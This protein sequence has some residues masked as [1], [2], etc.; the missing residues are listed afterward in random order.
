VSPG[1]RNNREDH[2]TV[3]RL[4]AMECSAKRCWE[5]SGVG[6]AL[7]HGGGQMPPGGLGLFRQAV[8]ADA[9]GGRASGHE[10]CVLFLTYND[11]LVGSGD[12]VP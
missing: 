11:V 9:P 4:A 2:C 6:R 12:V 3:M 5:N 7:A 8:L 10:L 1:D